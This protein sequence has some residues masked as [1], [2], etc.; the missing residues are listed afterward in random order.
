MSAAAPQTPSKKVASQLEKVDM[1][2]TP[3]KASIAVN[4]DFG[5]SAFLA[6]EKALAVKETSTKT[7]QEDTDDI[8]GKFVGDVD[9]PEEE[10]PGNGGA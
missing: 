2:K 10:W 8:H 6:K 4:D 9:L 3:S 5:D 7:V 1:N